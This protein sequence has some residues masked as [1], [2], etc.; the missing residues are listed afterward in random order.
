MEWIK[1]LAAPL[2][3]AL[4]GYC[5]NYIAVKML[6]R[7]LNPVKIGNYTLP[8]TPGII[9]KR[10]PALARAVGHAVGKSLVGE[11]EIREILCSENMKDAVAGSITTALQ[12]TLTEKSIREIAAMA[13]DED[14]YAA[15]KEAAVDYVSDKIVEGIQSIDIADLIVT[16]GTAAVKQMGG[17]I[18]MFVNADMIASFA[19]PIGAKVESYIA[20]NG[21]DLIQSKVQDEV[22]N[23][24][25]KHIAELAG[26][27]TMDA[28]RVMIGDMYE[29][30]LEKEISGIVKAFDI[31]GIVEKKI[32]EMDVKELEELIMSVM[33]HELGVIV[34]LGALIGFVLGMI[35]LA[36]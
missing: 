26:I 12:T 28:L 23:L 1:L 35:N 34:N 27:E 2:V 19:G 4:I 21:K 18:A 20:S 8:F 11:D 22:E 6:F 7:P 16:E 25:G 24:E 31:C 17:M 10:K 32:N 9:P 5:T 30:M 29:G 36:F 13:M 3:G 14:K 33:K 15:K